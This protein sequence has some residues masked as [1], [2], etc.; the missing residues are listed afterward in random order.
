MTSLKWVDS[1][2][3]SKFLFVVAICTNNLEEDPFV[4]ILISGNRMWFKIFQKISTNS[5][6]FL[7]R[8]L[9]CYISI[10]QFKNFW[11]YEV[12]R[13]ILWIVSG[14]RNKDAPFVLFFS[15][16]F[17]S[18]F[19]QWFNMFKDLSIE[20]RNGQTQFFFLSSAQFGLVR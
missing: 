17:P 14:F 4:T 15:L 18:S 20:S 6:N 10:I 16:N 12:K 13:C 11:H 3:I 5:I 1:S 2:V 7:L 9:G 19:R 8:V